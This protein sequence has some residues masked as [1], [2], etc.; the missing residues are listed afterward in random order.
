MYQIREIFSSWGVLDGAGL[1][2]IILTSGT[3]LLE[4]FCHQPNMSIIEAKHVKG[5][6]DLD[7]GNRIWVYSYMK[8]YLAS[9]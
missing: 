6:L 3:I 9:I 8:N 5:V 2:S 1:H 7:P 4:K